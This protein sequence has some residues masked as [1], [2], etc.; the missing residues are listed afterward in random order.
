[1]EAEGALCAS[2][3]TGFP[4]ADIELA[5]SSASVVTDGDQAKADALC[6]EILDLAWKHR[7]D[8]VYEIEPLA[9]SLARAA[10]LT[11]GPVVLLDHYDNAA[12]GGSMDSMTVLKG[13][14]EAGLDNVA[15]FAVCDPERSEEHTSELPSLMRISYAVFCLKKKNNKF[16]LITT[17][18]INN[19]L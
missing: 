9:T 12:S 11:E 6:R 15:A 1:M 8:F 7:A 13:I 10:E 3:F 18:S 5:G 14:L 16:R 4:H 2:F 19:Q 17:T